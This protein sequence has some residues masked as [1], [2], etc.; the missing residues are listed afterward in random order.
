MY[1]LGF[2]N[3]NAQTIDSNSVINLGS[4]YR[5]NSYKDNC[6]RNA[7]QL[8]NDTLILNQAGMYE[9]TL[10]L[11]ISAP[12]AGDAVIQLYQNGEAIPGALATETIATATTEYHTVT[13]PYVFLVDNNC[14]LGNK[15]VGELQI[16]AVNAGD[17]AITVNNI[18]GTIAKVVY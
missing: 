13:I 5:R 6:G 15:T 16:T 3:S 1:I 11:V 10:S 4:V 12:A 8:T 17:A 2:K 14:V 9:L 18:L 7:F